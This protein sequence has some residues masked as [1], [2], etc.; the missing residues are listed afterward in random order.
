MLEHQ[1]IHQNSTAANQSEKDISWWQDIFLITIMLSLFFS[2]FLGIRP[3]NVPDEARYSE[4]AREMVI[5]GD[6][7]TP[8]LNTIK[9]FEKPVFFYWIEASAIR[10]FGFSEGALRLPTLLFGLIGCLVTYITA[11]SLFDRRS[12]WFASF[13]LATS[14]L[15]FSMAHT[16]TLDMAVSVLLTLCLSAFIL[17]IDMPLGLRRSTLL[18]SAYAFAALAVLTK[19]LVGLLLPATIIGIWILLCNQWRCLAKINLLCGIGVFLAI[20]VPWHALVQ[21]ANPEFFH[22]YFIEQQ[23]LRYLTLYARR[24]QPDWFFIPVLILGFFPWIVF[25]FQALR[26]HWPAT[27]SDR[28]TQKKSLFLIL[29][30][31]VIFAFFSFS[32]S[33]LIPYIL[34]ILPPLAM[35]VG[36]YISVHTD[37]NPSI[38]RKAFLAIF[39]MAVLI[40][41]GL[42]LTPYFD[43]VNDSTLS[44]IFLYGMGFCLLL[45]TSLSIMYAYR[46]LPKP[47]LAILFSTMSVFLIL[48]NVAVAAVDTRSIKPLVIVLEQYL[49]PKD[50]V[51]AYHHYYQDL[52]FYLQRRV[53]V[54]ECRGEL[55]F[56]MRHQNTRTFMINDAEFWQRFNAQPPIYAV[57]RLTTYKKLE[58][59]HPNMHLL[60]TTKDNV[61]VTNTS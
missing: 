15:Y 21:Q 33:K 53:T 17:A 22:F 44:S 9:Y 20:V 57:M 59:L 31:A 4:I 51:I 10:F 28:I 41:V 19:G 26:H 35:L 13:A 2:I 49:K 14:V 38:F 42:F 25:L 61:L 24:Y 1:T 12:G 32:K 18:L 56:G 3:L 40:S 7:I 46:L 60:A 27:W 16:I 47:A 11:R 43:E 45:G 8:R 58:T 48:T 36:H 39:C 54:V 29:W 5:S 52:P 50:E 37:Q 34:P 23:F 30:A 55:D 6:Y